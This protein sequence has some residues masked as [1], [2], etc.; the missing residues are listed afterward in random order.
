MS[1]PD[2]ITISF[3]DNSGAEP[4]VTTSTPI[5]ISHA[6][7]QALMSWAAATLFGG[8]MMGGAPTF[9]PTEQQIADAIAQNIYS[10]HINDAQNW[11]RQQAAQAAMAA[12]PQI[13]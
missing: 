6:G 12:I 5:S 3:T 2:T 4:V 11:M 9:T 7:M 10:R 13:I 8:G 1:A